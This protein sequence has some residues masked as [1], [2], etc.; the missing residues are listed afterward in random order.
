MANI[1]QIAFT[2]PI[3]SSVSNLSNFAWNNMKIE[4]ARTTETIISNQFG[5]IYQRTAAPLDGVTLTAVQIRQVLDRAGGVIFST[6]EQNKRSGAEPDFILGE[7]GKLRANPKK[8]IRSADGTINIEIESKKRSAETNSILLADQLQKAAIKDLINYFRQS[9]PGAKIPQDWLDQL[10][11]EPNLPQP[12]VPIGNADLSASAQYSEMPQTQQQRQQ[13]EVPQ[14]MPQQSSPE[15]AQ[16]QSAQYNQPSETSYSGNS[17]T[18]GYSRSSYQGDTNY[19]PA[20]STYN[21]GTT[22]SFTQG[23]TY[24]GAQPADLQ[25]A[26]ANAKLVASVAKELGIDPVT[27][28]AVMLV[29]SGGNNRAVGDNGT[30]FGLFQ[31]HQGGELGNLTK[32]QAFDPVTNARVALSEFQRQES[33][34]SDPGQLAAAS[35]RP[36]DAANYAQKVNA[37]LPEARR[38]LAESDG[39]IAQSRSSSS[40]ELVSV[41]QKTESGK[42]ALLSPA[43]AAAFKAAEADLGRSIPITSAGRTRAEQQALWDNRASNPY[44]VAPPGTS[45][46]EGGNAIDIEPNPPADVRQALERHGF[47]NDVPGDPVHWNYRA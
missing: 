40:G 9:N 20:R 10:A 34:Y 4:P 17:G 47:R 44:P 42:E 6:A 30:S 16:P 38:L 29:E 43:A 19:S 32:E 46:H 33:K 22:P 27:A 8:P 26:A 18:P 39:I 7:D 45:N 41:G 23:T 36:A 37:T 2:Q 25:T 13:T 3:G 15:V 21:D 31:L 35:Q 14:S 28:V 24:D 5:D 12:V 11:K 1:E